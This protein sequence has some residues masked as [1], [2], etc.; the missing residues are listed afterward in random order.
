MCSVPS[1]GRRGSQLQ[2]LYFLWS[3]WCHCSSAAVRP[4][5]AHNFSAH[6]YI[7]CQYATKILT[8]LDT[9]R[10]YSNHAESSKAFAWF[11]RSPHRQWGV[12]RLQS[13][14]TSIVVVKVAC[15][16]IRIVNNILCDISLL[17]AVIV[18]ADKSYISDNV[19]LMQNWK[20][21]ICT[22]MFR[23]NICSCVRYLA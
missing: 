23:A 12:H 8:E 15:M 1:D 6:W 9:L 10:R 22:V 5:G 20:P 2:Y 21:I 19:G 16:F 11:S 7:V 3:S 17:L 14:N 4:N 18:S 13:L